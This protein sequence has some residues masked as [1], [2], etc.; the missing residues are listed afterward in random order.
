MRTAPLAGRASDPSWAGADAL[1]AAEFAG[2]LHA[3]PAPGERMLIKTGA[4]AQALRDQH[5]RAWLRALGSPGLGSWLTCAGLDSRRGV[6]ADG[7]EIRVIGEQ[8]PIRLIAAGENVDPVLVT[9]TVKALYSKVL[10]G[11]RAP[12]QVS[13]PRP[14]E[15]TLI[16]GRLLSPVAGGTRELV[17][18][19]SLATALRSGAGRDDRSMDGWHALQGR[20]RPEWA[21][22]GQDTRAARR[23][24]GV[25]GD[26]DG[27]PKV[28]VLGYPDGLRHA[29]LADG[30]HVPVLGAHDPVLARSDEYG[31][32]LAVTLPVRACDLYLHELGQSAFEVSGP[33][34]GRL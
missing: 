13:G 1:H 25:L 17:Y 3:A 16:P 21:A 14:D 23:L 6:L 26:C 33:G 2:A 10:D 11:A 7:S 19:A 24:A 31:P 30:T 18:A 20:R 28:A 8:D 29:R 5:G 12:V 22:S 34:G 9:V 32:E 15:R 27:I 4:V